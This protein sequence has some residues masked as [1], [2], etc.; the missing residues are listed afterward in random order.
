MNTAHI[1]MRTLIFKFLVVN[2]RR[3]SLSVDATARKGRKGKQK[4]TKKGS[5]T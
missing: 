5:R 4:K 3:A 2:T 1:A